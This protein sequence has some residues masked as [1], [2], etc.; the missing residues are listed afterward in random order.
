SGARERPSFCAS[1]WSWCSCSG[2]PFRTVI[3]RN[4]SRERRARGPPRCRTAAGTG[5]PSQMI[6]FELLRIH[7]RRR[8]FMLMPNATRIQWLRE[9]GVRIG[10]DCLVHTPYFSTE[11]YLIEIGDH[12]AIS[13]GTEFI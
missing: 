13:A 4:D 2:L 9:D 1:R 8:L 11:P 6:Y 12:V 3:P 7:L 10:N 5:I